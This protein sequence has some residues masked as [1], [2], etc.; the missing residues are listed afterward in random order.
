MTNKIQPCVLLASLLFLFTLNSF[1]QQAEYF[2]NR[3]IIKYQSEEQ[4][5]QIRSKMDADPKKAVQQILSQKGV[6]RN[7][8][9]LNKRLQQKVSQRNL[10]SAD[11][12]LRIRELFFS[13]KINPVQ[14]AGKINSIPGIAY[15]EP[16]Y[17]RKMSFVPNDSLLEKYIDTHNFFDAWDIS[18][19]SSKI[20]IAINDGGVGYTHIDLDDNLWVNQDEVPDAVRPQADQNGDGT[21]TSTEIYEYLQDNGQDYNGDNA[22]TLEDALHEDSSFMDGDDSDNNNFTDDLF[23]WDFWESGGI[24]SPVVTDNNP[25]HNQDGTDHGTHVAGIAAAET[26]NDTAIAGAAF[27]TTYMPVKTGGIADDPSTPFNE[28]NAIGFGFDGIIYAAENGADVINCSWG[29]ESFSQA[30]QDI[31]NLTTEMG[32]LVV[33]AAG[34]SSNNTLNYPAGYNNVLSVGSVFTNGT[35]SNFSNYGYELDVL[36]TGGDIESTSYNNE[37]TSKTGTSMSA[38]VA[39][40]L[41]ALVKEV[42]PGWTAERIATQIRSSATFVYEKNNESLNH[43]L[44]HGSLNAFEAVNTNNPGLK[45]IS[46]AFVNKEGDKLFVNEQGSLQLT[47][48]NY[49]RSTSGLELQ[50][51]SVNE[52]GIIL[53]NQSQQ[54]GSIATGETVEVSFDLLISDNFDLREIPTLRINFL[55]QNMNYEDFNIVQ[56]E[57]ILYDILAANNVKTSFATDGT[58]GFTDPLTGSGGIGFIPRKPSGN[59]QYD[60][61]NNILYEGG[62]MVEVDGEMYDAV[63][64]EEGL[65]RDFIPQ[66]SFVVTPGSNSS[67]GNGQFFTDTDSTRWAIIDQQTY[68]FDDP[69]IKNVVLVEYTI[70]NPSEFVVMNNV[71]AGLFNDWDIGNAFNNNAN[72]SQSDSVLYLSDATSG[73]TE[74]VVAVAHLGPISSAL[75]VDNTIDGQQ[76]SVTFGLYDG[77]TDTEK[78]NALTAGTVR[79]SVQ[80]TDASAVIASGPY[81]IEPKAEITV[82]FVYAFGNDV[83]ELRNQISEAR[84]RNV[85]AVSPI[86]RAVSDQVPQQTKLFQNYPNPFNAS[87]QLRIDLE[88]STDLTLAVFDILGR[89]V[90]VLAEG[91]FDAGSHFIRFNAGQLSSGTYFVQLRTEYGTDSIPITLVK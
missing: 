35:K 81:T 70:K 71:Y 18:Q 13:R 84:S 7:Q 62:F 31:I 37:L 78:S 86:G 30:E 91:Q 54:L 77:F 2:P 49:G 90:R 51:E 83:N 5:Q 36:A 67:T 82:G 28:S 56:Y 22:I 75:A 27:N 40:G 74:P 20:V 32:A 9:L 66:Q 79:T 45:V 6:Y 12:V 38:P 59:G 55:D 58:I 53:D 57:K 61:G 39:S 14:L 15:A 46:S 21:I 26:D 76:D 87:T 80:Q 50:L 4:L 52:K 10:S 72:F 42:N 3:L 88:Q 48:T 23:G 1:G 17:L 33:A 47:L 11:E 89:K 65:S 34:N 63:R 25:I 8:P 41:A 69:G 64:A 60:E 24:D 43:K 29:G 44:G 73:S 16:R 85:F 19:G 68:A